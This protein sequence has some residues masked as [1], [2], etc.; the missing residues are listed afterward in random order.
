VLGDF[1][2][3]SRRV[4]LVPRRAAFTVLLG[5]CN[6]CGILLVVIMLAKGLALPVT[7]LQCLVI[8][9]LALQATKACAGAR[10]SPALAC[11]G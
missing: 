11:F 6:Q 10:L 4:L 9:P 1:S 3:A 7:W 2:V 8:V 5:L